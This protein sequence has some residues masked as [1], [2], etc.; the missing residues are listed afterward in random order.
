MSG[1]DAL[2]SIQVHEST[3]RVLE[4]YKRPGQTYENVIEEFVEQFPPESFLKEM[5]RRLRESPPLELTEVRRRL[6]ARRAKA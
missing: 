2:T 4:L 6:A 3:R 5:E 1:T